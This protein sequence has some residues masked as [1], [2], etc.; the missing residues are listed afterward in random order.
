[1]LETTQTKKIKSISKILKQLTNE[2]TITMDNDG[3]SIQVLDKNHICYVGL[4]IP[5]SFFDDYTE[6]L[7]HISVDSEE[8]YKVLQRIKPVDRLIFKVD[9]NDTSLKIILEGESKRTFSIRLIDLE[10]ESPVPPMI[11]YP[12]KYTVHNTDLSTGLKDCE[13]YDD[14]LRF[15]NELLLESNGDYGE[16]TGTLPLLNTTGDS[17]STVNS[18]FSLDYLNLIPELFDTELVLGLGE[19]MPILIESVNDSIIST[20]MLIAP[21]LDTTQ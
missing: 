7:T 10:Y 13:L 3:L 8:L 21:R 16:Y 1:M 12:C 6:S 20:R 15:R 11:E 2:L 4:N 17:N 5:Y 18:V 9:E 14:R 19:D